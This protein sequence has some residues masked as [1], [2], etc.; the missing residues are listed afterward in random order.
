MNSMGINSLPHELKYKIAEYLDTRSLVSFIKAG[1]RELDNNF[2]W[3]QRCKIEYSFYSDRIKNWKEKYK[4]LYL[5]KCIHCHNNTK[6][7]NDFYKVK[8]CRKCELKHI[9]YHTVSHT[10]AKTL[11][12]LNKDELKTFKF[13]YRVNPF[14]YTQKIKLYLKDDIMKY[15]MNSEGKYID[16]IQQRMDIHMNY[17]MNR[18]YKFNILLSTL[19]NNYNISVN[20]LTSILSNV[21]FYSKGLFQKFMR[22]NNRPIIPVIHKAL[23]LDFI[24]TYT[25]IMAYN[26]YNNFEDILYDYLLSNMIT[27]L[28][29]NINEYIDL[30]INNF[31][32][33]YRECIIR[34]TEILQ[35]YSE[36]K[37]RI[38]IT[39]ILKINTIYR[40]IQ[41]GTIFQ[42]P[43]IKSQLKAHIL[44][45]NFLYIHTNIQSII[46]EYNI[47]GKIIDKYSLYM[48]TL[49]RW[50][51]GNP[52]ARHLLPRELYPLVYSN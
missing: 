41:F 27:I 8:V 47:T 28:P 33:T 50:Y 45:H 49:N 2:L 38:S 23:E 46:F 4:K 40:Y 6:L 42:L 16:S 51:L 21:N 29:I 24:F 44:L 10:K 3:K 19:I 18:L 12:F 39:H 32:K 34:K 26:A 30:C 14:N 22:Y 20:N 25:D 31:N 35:V 11:Y 15:V 9:K 13:I 17:H 37:N 48:T 36:L 52:H 5:A 1:Q 43:G 7:Y